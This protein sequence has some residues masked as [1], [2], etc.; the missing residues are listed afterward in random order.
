MGAKG[1]QDADKTLKIESVRKLIV[2]DL[3]RT[4]AECEKIQAR[5]NCPPVFYHKLGSQFTYKM[6][7]VGVIDHAGGAKNGHYTARCRT[8]NG[9][10]RF[11]DEKPVAEKLDKQGCS[12]D[13]EL[14]REYQHMRA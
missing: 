9:W 13:S 2:F 7:L 11:D 1:K 8:R 14:R 6:K 5:V 12:T 4:V 3:K 10:Y